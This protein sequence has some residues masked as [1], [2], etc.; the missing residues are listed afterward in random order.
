M[1][2]ALS[3]ASSAVRFI[4]AAPLWVGL[5]AEITGAAFYSERLAMQKGVIACLAGLV[6]W[7][8]ATSHLV[9]ADSTDALILNQ[10]N[11]VSGGKYLQSGKTDE[12]FGR[13]EGN[14]QN[15]MQLLVSKT[16]PG[17]NTLNLQGYQIDWSYSKDA[18]DYGSG[19]ITFSNDPVWASVPLGTAI[20]INEAQ[21]AWY[22]IDTPDSTTNPDGDLP[23]QGGMQRDGDIDGLGVLHGTPYSG[24]PSVEKLFDFSSNTA[25]NPYAQATGNMQPGPNWN[26]N[27]WAGQQSNGDF[28]ILQ[29]FGDCHVRRR[30]IERR[31]RGRW[32]VHRQQ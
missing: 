27:V 21:S 1:C 14:G 6:L 22:L 5:P 8:S 12:T 30:D 18:A 13:I 4:L 20:T 24:D 17:K 28:S 16:D 9:V 10:G 2:S 11:A 32:S 7:F 3:S 31:Y 19:T 26:I 15:W 23:G 25:W 29:L